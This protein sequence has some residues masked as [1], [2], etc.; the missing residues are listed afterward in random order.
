MMVPAVCHGKSL[1]YLSKNGSIVHKENMHSFGNS[2][3]L[4]AQ[5]TIKHVNM[6]NTPDTNNKHKKKI[7]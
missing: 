6:I 2:L 4:V 1:V 7:S 5:D 3:N